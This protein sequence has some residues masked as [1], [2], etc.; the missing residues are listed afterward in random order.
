MR[1][2]LACLWSPSI[3]RL[4][5]KEMMQHRSVNGVCMNLSAATVCC[6]QEQEAI[7][8]AQPAKQAPVVPTAKAKRTLGSTLITLGIIAGVFGLLMVPLYSK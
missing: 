1:L 5:G 3:A 6:V 8:Q 2:S 4:T 7:R